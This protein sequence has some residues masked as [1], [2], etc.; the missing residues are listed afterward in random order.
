MARSQ[1]RRWTVQK[2]TQQRLLSLEMS[3]CNVGPWL[4]PGNLS[5]KQFPTLIK[6]LP[7]WYWWLIVLRLYDN[8]VY[9]KNPLS[10]WES[11]EGQAESM[12]PALNKNVGH[13]VSNT[14]SQEET[15]HICYCIFIAGCA[16]CDPSWK[17]WL[18]FFNLTL[19][20]IFEVI[21]QLQGSYKNNTG[22][23]HILHW[24]SIYVKIFHSNRTFT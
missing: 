5:G 19:K 4:A 13:S 10:F 11:K 1:P 16:L 2:R 12:W 21:L 15:S 20:K 14:L 3:A 22:F 7:D 8:V 17:G 24:V 6:N 23:L 18:W 9:A